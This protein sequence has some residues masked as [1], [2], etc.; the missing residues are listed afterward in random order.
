MFDLQY[1]MGINIPHLSPSTVNSFITDKTGFYNS[2]VLRAP[3]MGSGY[4]CRGTAVEH[5]INVWLETGVTENLSQIA[6]DKYKEE[7]I[8]SGCS[9]LADISI[10]E[11]I[12]GLVELA[13]Q[14]Y[15]DQFSDCK[16]LVQTQRKVEA[17]L[18][19]IDRV[20][21]GYLD[22]FIMGKAVR[23]C[24]TSSKTPSSLSQSYILQG[25]FYNL[26]TGLPVTFDFFIANKKP[27][28]KGITMTED[29]CAFGISYLTAAAKAIEELENCNDP[30]RVMQLMTFPDLSNMWT[31]SDRSRAAKEWGIEL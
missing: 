6:I 19:G 28:Y 5:A 17:N 23:D 18:K 26:A 21:L 20:M 1:S 2:K 4:T 25:A 15:L 24:K 27:V 16:T 22:F 7:M 11:A 29:Q 30:R 10:Q 8:K 12:P 9:L 14:T 3:F 31:D 13:Y